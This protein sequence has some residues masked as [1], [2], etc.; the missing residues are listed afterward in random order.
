[1]ATGPSR[2]SSISGGDGDF[3]YGDRTAGGAADGKKNDT[4]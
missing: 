1:M 3:C 2:S 4:G